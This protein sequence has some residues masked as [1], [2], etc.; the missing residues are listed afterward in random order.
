MNPRVVSVEGPF[1]S[2]MAFLSEISR[3]AWG[4]PEKIVSSRIYKLKAN[5]VDS[6][7]EAMSISKSYSSSTNNSSN[8][9]QNHTVGF[10]LLNMAT[11]S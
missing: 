9:N 3:L 7:V 2:R 11:Q 4:S 8:A 5:N 10:T 6:S 1:S